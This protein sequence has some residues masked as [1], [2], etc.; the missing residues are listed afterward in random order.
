MYGLE[1]VEKMMP[2]TVLNEELALRNIMNIGTLSE[3]MQDAKRVEAEYVR[4]DHLRNAEMPIH[5]VDI[6]NDLRFEMSA[7]SFKTPKPATA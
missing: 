3:N 1:P 5:L 4:N 7:A 6:R 2:V